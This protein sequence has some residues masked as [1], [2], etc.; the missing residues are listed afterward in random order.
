MSSL[1][2]GEC[3]NILDRSRRQTRDSP[4][5]EPQSTAPILTL[6]AGWLALELSHVVQGQKFT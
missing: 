1:V 4:R 6:G 5:I 2:D 3:F